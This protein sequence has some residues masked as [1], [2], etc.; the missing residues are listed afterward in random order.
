MYEVSIKVVLA[1]LVSEH[2]GVLV[3]TGQ[4]KWHQPLLE[5]FVARC[6]SIHRFKSCGV[7]AVSTGLR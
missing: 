3:D 2:L 4:V 5:L 1:L 6:V 7:Q